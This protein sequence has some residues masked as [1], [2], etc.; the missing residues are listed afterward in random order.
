LSGAQPAAAFRRLIKRALV[1]AK[2][3]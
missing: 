2:R 1:D 3:P